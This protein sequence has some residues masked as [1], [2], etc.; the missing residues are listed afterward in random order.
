LLYIVTGNPVPWVS[1]A[2]GNDYWTDSIVALHINTGQLAWGY[3]TVHHDIWDYDVTNPPVLFDLPYNGTITPAVGVASKTGWVYILNRLTGKPILGAPEK[4]VPQL[5]GAA[6]AYENLAKTQPFPV[7]EPFTR[8]CNTKKDWPGK[9][10][11]GKPY[12]TGC[13]FHPYAYVK[14]QPTFVA[15]DPGFE[16]GVDW[17]PSAYNAA[18]HDL[19]LCSITGAGVSLGALPKQQTVVHAG[20]PAFGTTF[21][22]P[23]PTV[24]DLNQV[25][26]MDMTNNTVAWK[27]N[28][29]A[30]AS[31]KVPNSRCTGVLSTDGNLVFAS[32]TNANKLAA[33]DAATGKLL[34]ESPKLATPPSGPPITYSGADGKQYVAILGAGGQMYGFSL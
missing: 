10:P 31:K 14:G 11:D 7:G 21:G 30:P 8:Q 3:Q 13:I 5:K 25:V 2:A 19:Y 22:P 27:T 6:A 4:K 16:G 12:I 24:V 29:P 23:S 26:A 32:E 33:Y 18:T 20:Q 1:R 15:E 28:Q 17:Q 9:A 34:W